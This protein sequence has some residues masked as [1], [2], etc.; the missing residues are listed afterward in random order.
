M[1]RRATSPMIA[2][3][4]VR[5]GMTGFVEIAEGSLYR[6]GATVPLDGRISWTPSGT[7]GYQAMN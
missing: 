4:I 7:G 2:H 5:K 3:E 1:T 6:L